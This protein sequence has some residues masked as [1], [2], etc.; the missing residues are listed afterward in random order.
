MHSIESSMSDVMYF[1]ERQRKGG[2]KMRELLARILPDD[3]M[4]RV[5]SESRSWY[6]R[7][8]CGHEFDIWSMGGMRY[9][10]VGHP[11]RLVTCPAC[12]ST[13]FLKLRKREEIDTDCA[14]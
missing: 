4:E 11:R 9:K 1:A 7:C 2:A 10:G 3:V 5:E 14:G 13:E 12:G 8:S 6:F